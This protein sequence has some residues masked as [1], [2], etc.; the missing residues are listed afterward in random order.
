MKGYLWGGLL[1]G[2]R[3]VK[4]KAIFYSESHFWVARK[5]PISVVWSRILLFASLADILVGSV[6]DMIL[7]AMD[8]Q[9]GISIIIGRILIMI[10]LWKVLGRYLE[11]MGNVRRQGLE[12]WND[13]GGMT[14]EYGGATARHKRRLLVSAVEF[15]TSRRRRKKP[16]GS[17]L[18]KYW[19][20]W[21]SI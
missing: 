15:G 9:S 10:K 14:N 12:R 17:I 5:M 21:S 18:N 16:L 1:I 8:C 19:K 20:G 3:I 4:Q 2:T 7:A 11:A 6:F 13:Y